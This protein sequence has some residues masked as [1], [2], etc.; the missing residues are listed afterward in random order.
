MLDDKSLKSCGSLPRGESDPAARVY[1]E[2]QISLSH[3]KSVQALIS[4]NDVCQW[5]S[6]TEARHHENSIERRSVAE[7]RISI[8]EFALSPRHYA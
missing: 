4:I 5:R 2:N 3:H 7:A 6:E 1:P 8:C